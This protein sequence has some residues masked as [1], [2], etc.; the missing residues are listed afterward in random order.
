MAGHCINLSQGKLYT[1]SYAAFMNRFNDYFDKKVPITEKDS[2]DIYSSTT[3][4]ILEKLSSPIPLCQFCDV[5]NRTYGNVWE[6]SNKE[7][8]EWALVENK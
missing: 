5:K 4:E 3:E 7:L 6:R 1:C 8:C 2:V